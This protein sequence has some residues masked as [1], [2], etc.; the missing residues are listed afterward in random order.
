MKAPDRSTSDVLSERHKLIFV[1]GIMGSELFHEKPAFGELTYEPV[2][3]HEESVFWATLS[4][5]PKVLWREQPLV[6]GRVIRQIGNT[7]V[8]GGF[9]SFLEG[10]GYVEDADLFPF[11][12]DWRQSNRIS[13]QKLAEQIVTTA[14]EGDQKMILVGHS[15]G[16]MIIRLVLGDP[17]FQSAAGRVSKA[18]LIASPGRGSSNAFPTLQSKPD[19]SFWLDLLLPAKHL[20][21]PS[22]QI[23]LMLAMHSFDSL[24]ELLPPESE[25]ILV[26]EDDFHWS[27]LDPKFWPAHMKPRLAAATSVH[28]VIRAKQPAS[29]VAI[30]S[31]GQT[32]DREY[33]VDDLFQFQGLSKSVKGD[34][35]VSHASA[36]EG[37]EPINRHL[38]A[39]KI[40]HGGVPDSPECC[41]VVEQLIR[42]G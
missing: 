21:R 40:P 42:Q 28:D 31:S 15:M 41:K 32:T 7:S 5:I 8:Y 4:R 22:L 38:L 19:L 37:I 34:N 16:G 30:Y 20:L 6:V 14:S 11:A 33:L 29:V 10:L 24:L 13:A 3:A 36:V 39:K 27:A 2:W 26:S 25:Q 17:A 9:L 23:D 35:R 1:P 12:Y 18:I